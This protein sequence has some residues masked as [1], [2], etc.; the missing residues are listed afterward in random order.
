MFPKSTLLLIAFYLLLVESNG[1]D[2]PDSTI[3][4]DFEILINLPSTEVKNQYQSNLCWCFSTVS[5]IESELIRKNVGVLDLSEMYIAH[6]VYGEKAKKYVRMHSY[7]KFSGGG[8]PH[9]VMN[10]IKKFGIVPESSFHVVEKGSLN[11]N[12]F[13]LDHKLKDYLD[14]KISGSLDGLD[15]EWY[16]KFQDT[17][18]SNIGELPDSFMYKDK[19]YSPESF[20]IE[21]NFNPDDYVLISSFNHHPFYSRFIL[22]VPDNWSLGLVYNVPVNELLEI[23]NHSLQKGYSIVW[24]ADISEKGFLKSE[25]VVIAPYE[26]YNQESVKKR[27]NVAQLPYDQFVKKYLDFSSPYKEIEV[28]Q[29]LRQEAFDNHQTKDDH[30][31]HIIGKAIDKNGKSYFYV[32]NSWGKKYYTKGYLFVS[33]SYFNFKTISIMLHKDGIPL[34]IRKKLKL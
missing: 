17:L 9:D 2:D 23:T 26:L 16:Q 18:N 33:E 20:L 4:P 11:F 7:T 27:N 32:K 31:M 24:S 14:S 10:V 22:E 3:H 19:L 28:T 21:L 5:L 13:K 6:K 34:E 8:Q 25:G 29:E 12:H 30:G 15:K 1:S